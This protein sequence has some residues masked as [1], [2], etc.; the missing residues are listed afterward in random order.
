MTRGARLR[1]DD[2]RASVLD[3]LYEGLCLVSAHV[4]PWRC[5]RPTQWHLVMDAH[6]MWKCR[7]IPWA[8]M[9]S[10]CFLFATG[11]LEPNQESRRQY[12]VCFLQGSQVWFWRGRSAIHLVAIVCCV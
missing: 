2:F 10:L 12:M 7:A 11:V 6:V 3:A 4:H 8:F 9:H 1:L 5:L